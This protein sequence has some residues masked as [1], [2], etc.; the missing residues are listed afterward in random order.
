MWDFP[1]LPLHILSEDPLIRPDV[2]G[3][4]SKVAKRIA[5]EEQITNININRLQE[6]VDK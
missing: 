6:M 2:V 3:L 5:F 1:W 4:P